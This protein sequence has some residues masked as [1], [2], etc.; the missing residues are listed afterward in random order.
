M[1]VTAFTRIR[2]EYL[3]AQYRAQ[4]AALGSSS[5][6]A[7][8]LTQAQS[9]FDEPSSSGIASQLSAFWSAWSGLSNDPT[10][11]AAKVAVVTAGKQLAGTLKEVDA[12]LQGIEA[13]SAQQFNAIAGAHGELQSD[14]TQIA[15]LNEQIKLSLQAKQQPNELEDRRDLLLDKVSELRPHQRHQGK[16]RDR[17][18]HVRRRRRTARQGLGGRLA[19]GDSCSNQ[20]GIAAAVNHVARLINPGTY[21]WSRAA[22]KLRAQSGKE[23]LPLK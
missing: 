2:N 10:S 12:Q 5:T 14:A 21:G 22:G 9:A 15:Q 6:Q 20:P 23:S 19:P 18:G 3:D 7:N 4:N 11:E 13:Q 1:S 17:Y 16:R 8:A